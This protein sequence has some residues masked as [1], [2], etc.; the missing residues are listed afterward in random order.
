M[1]RGT[2]RQSL[3]V[4]A[5][6]AVIAV[7]ALSE[8]LPLNGLSTATISD[9]F[10]VFF[11]PAGY[12]FSIWGVIY[13]ALLAFA[14]YQALP[15]QKDNPRLGTVGYLF[16]L[17]AVANIG[18]IFLWHYQLFVWTLVA[19]VSLLIVLIAIYLTLG[20]GRSKVSLWE[21]LFAHVPFSLYLGWITVATVANVTD[22][23]K[24]LNWDGWGLSPELWAVLMLVVATVIA[25]AVVFTRL[26]VAY[27][28]VIAWAFV[29]IAVKQSATPAVAVTALAMVAVV[30][31]VMVVSQVL[32]RGKR[33]RAGGPVW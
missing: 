10:K 1:D 18:W 20:I 29:G 17:S 2:V 3:V 21:K 30:L 25:S 11:V 15:A 14:A 22:V 5:V 27:L 24:Y 16:L 4:L 31:A 7:N 12:V 33:V 6:L 32:V 9:S 26:D 13:L 8:I 19:M 28:L 23:L